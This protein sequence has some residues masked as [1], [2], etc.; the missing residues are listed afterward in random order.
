M[1]YRP[2]EPHAVVLDRHEGRLE[3]RGALDEPGSGVSIVWPRDARRG[4]PLIRAIGGARRVVDATAGFGV[5]A[6]LLAQSGASVTLIERSPVMAALLRDALERAQRSDP[7]TAARLV[8]VEGDARERLRGVLE[9]LSSE[10]GT[11]ESP[12]SPGSPGSSS[13]PGSAGA[14]GIAVVLD[15]MFPPKRRASALPS[16]EMQFLASIVGADEDSAELLALA[17]STCRGRV[18]VKRA[19]DAP[20][21]APDVSF[22]VESKLVRFDVYLPRA[23]APRTPA[24]SNTVPAAERAGAHGSSGTERT[25]EA[26]ARLAETEERTA[27]TAWSACSATF[28]MESIP[29]RGA[30]V[31]LPREEARHATGSRRL[32][33]GELVA[34]VDGHGTMA[35]AR[36]TASGRR[37]SVSLEI[38][39]RHV[40][41]PPMPAV[42]IATAIPKGD[43]WSALLDM[44]AQLGAREV[45]PLDCE[46]SVIRSRS[47]NRGRAARILIEA[48]KQSRRAWCPRLDVGCTPLVAAERAIESGSHVFVAHPGG[49]PART[50]L[51][52]ESMHGSEGGIVIL[53]GPEGGFTP[54]EIDSMVA[55]GV[56]T[57][58]LGD[59]VLRVETAVAAALAAA[60]I[61]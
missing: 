16:K 24:V 21:L 22:A 42:T 23:T 5:D 48:C 6:W 58:S 4:S 34:L 54:T 55:R 47:I 9:E 31:A 29:E 37:G 26:A 44:A 51:G 32:A 20:A 38:V 12:G 59:G 25:A 17:R 28:F 3:A 15:P 13:A 60:R 40:T 50:A 2:P 49:A 1:R 61:V 33:A 43:R 18:I 57:M 41:P 14:S 11:S 8:L 19:P 56:R 53:I 39:E 27:E 35:A 36:L 30:S 46:R 52:A 45:I 7:T 10:S